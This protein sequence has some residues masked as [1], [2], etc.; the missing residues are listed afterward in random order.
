MQVSLVDSGLAPSRRLSIRSWCPGLVAAGGSQTS[1][2]ISGL[3]TVA[4]HFSLSLPNRQLKKA[5]G[6]L[7]FQPRLS[8]FSYKIKS[9]SGI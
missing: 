8:A 4:L 2:F 6:P 5:G 9:E 1:I 7:G 3:A